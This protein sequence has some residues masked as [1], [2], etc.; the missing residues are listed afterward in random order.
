MSP[1][2]PTFAIVD[3]G[4]GNLF[5]VLHALAAVG[6]TAMSSTV[7][8]VVMTLVDSSPISRR[9]LVSPEIRPVHVDRVTQSRPLSDGKIGMAGGS[10]LGITQ[11]KA[12]VQNNPHLKAI[13]PV[14]SGDDDYRDRNSRFR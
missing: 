11:W 13:F 4:M 10:Y 12:A 7:A 8:D 6:Q 1:G 5:S 2:L 3:Y 9:A 14:V